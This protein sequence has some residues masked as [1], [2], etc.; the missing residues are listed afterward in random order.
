MGR[1]EADGERPPPGAEREGAYRRLFEAGARAFPDLRLSPVTFARHLAT[2]EA[3]G[4]PIAPAHAADFYLACACVERVRG[5]VEAFDRAHFGQLAGLLSTLRPSPDLVS[6]VRQVLSI[7]LFVEQPGVAPKITE[8]NGRSAL[9][10]WLRVI[11]RR[12]AIDLL[13]Q[14]GLTL[15]RG[16]AEEEEEDPA[17]ADAEGGYLKRRY[18]QPFNEALRTA[19]AAIAPEQRE[20]LRLHF[21][22][23]LTLD[24]L[25]ERFGVHRATIARRL[26]AAREAIR[27]EARRLI[28]AELGVTDAELDSLDGMMRSQLDLTLSGHR[29]SS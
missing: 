8:Y 18:R 13:R 7:K 1:D 25:A 23:G 28:R 3:A 10:T 9:S 14:R 24:Q 12:T 17:T 6:E 21:T 19:L 2:R 26:A 29:K 16:D 20:I 27:R 4:G 5:A 22:D 15:D 11:A